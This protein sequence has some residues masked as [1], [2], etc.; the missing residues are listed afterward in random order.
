MKKLARLSLVSGLLFV[1]A[2]THAG[3]KTPISPE[4]DSTPAPLTISCTNPDTFGFAIVENWTKDIAA[5]VKAGLDS[6]GGRKAV[7]EQSGVTITSWLLPDRSIVS[8][9]EHV[10]KD[11]VIWINRPLPETKEEPEEEPEGPPGPHDLTIL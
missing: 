3:D 9:S 2:L 10:G 8:I 5:K 6:C 1:T 11:A 4:G 7:Y